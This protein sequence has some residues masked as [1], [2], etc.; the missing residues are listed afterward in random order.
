MTILNNIM[1]IIVIILIIIAIL[2]MI[3]TILGFIRLPDE[4]TKIHAAG[5]TG[6]FA[7]ELA[8]IA[9]FIYFYQIMHVFE[10]KLILAIIF[11]FVTTP[12]TA[13]MLAQAII[14]NNK[15]TF[16]KEKNQVEPVLE[17]IKKYNK[18]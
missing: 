15:G 14:I 18:K 17:D 1:T 9:A 8:L 12:I 16:F 3:S 11:L 2:A 10:F 4:L 5:V 6:S 7:V 13:H